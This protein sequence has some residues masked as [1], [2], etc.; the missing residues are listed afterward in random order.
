MAYSTDL[1]AEFLAKGGTVSKIAE[2]TRA[3]ENEKDIYR[4]MREGKKAQSD[5]TTQVVK[6]EARQQESEQL[7]QSAFEARNQGHV[8]IGSEFGKVI[9]Q[10]EVDGF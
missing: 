7:M 3:I 6:D 9:V 1:V 8:V 5:A 4:A 10:T 2:G